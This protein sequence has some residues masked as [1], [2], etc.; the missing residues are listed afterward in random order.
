M[1]A[2]TGRSYNADQAACTHR[3]RYTHPKND[4][5]HSSCWIGRR[6]EPTLLVSLIPEIASNH[7]L[8]MRILHLILVTV[9]AL[10]AI[11][12]ILSAA[13]ERSQIKTDM[14]G[15]DL[16]GGGRSLRVDARVNADDDVGR[17][18]VH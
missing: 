9:V 4:P 14:A 18:V 16:V 1:A 17:P 10:L 6:R 3:M 7:A 8:T 15:R 2:L 13:A 5:L 11:A 12:A